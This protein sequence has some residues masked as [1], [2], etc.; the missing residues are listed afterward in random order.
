MEK[1]WQTSIS[2]AVSKLKSSYEWCDWSQSKVLSKFCSAVLD[3]ISVWFACT[4]IKPFSTHLN[5]IYWQVSNWRFSTT[6]IFFVRGLM[7]GRRPPTAFMSIFAARQIDK[8]LLLASFFPRIA[9]YKCFPFYGSF[10]FTIWRSRASEVL[11]VKASRVA[12]TAN[13][14]RK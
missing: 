9:H 3:V 8:V 5:N 10:S 11:L 4:F 6:F 7:S 14:R 2:N 13:M 12:R 1:V